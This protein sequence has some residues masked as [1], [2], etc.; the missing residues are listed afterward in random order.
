[1]IRRLSFAIASIFLAACSRNDAH[2]QQGSQPA[3]PVVTSGLVAFSATT[4]ERGQ[5]MLFK[6]R[7]AFAAHASLFTAADAGLHTDGVAVVASP[8][9]P[10]S[11]ETRVSVRLPK[12]SDGAL[13]VEAGAMRVEVKPRGFKARPV[14]WSENVAIY[15]DVAPS[16]DVYRVLGEQ[17]VED[18]YLASEERSELMFTYDIKLTDVAGLRL[19]D[20]TLEFLDAAGTPRLRATRPIAIDKAGKE[21]AGRLEV[22]GCSYDTRATGPWGRAVTPAGNSTCTVVAR[23]DGRALQYPVLVDPAWEATGKTKQTHAYHKLVVVQAGA[24]KD[25]VVLVGGTGSVASATELFD[26]NTGTWATAA[27]LPTSVTLGAGMSAAGLPNGVIVAAGGLSSG[28]S[29][30]AVASAVVRNPTSGLWFSAAAMDARA[31]HAMVPVTIGGKAVVLSIGGQ[32]SSFLG[33][34]TPALAGADYYEPP[35]IKADGSFD[36]TSGDNWFGPY[37]MNTTRAKH[38]ATVL[39]DGRVLVAGGEQYTSF[40]TYLQSAEIFDPATKAWATT[41]SMALPRSGLELQA[42]AGSGAIAAGGATSGSSTSALDSMEYFNGTT[43]TLLT[44]KLS[45]PRWFFASTR[46]SDGRLLFAGGEAYNPTTFISYVSDTADLFIPGSDPTTGIVTGAGSMN[47]LRWAQPMVNT[48]K[49]ALTTGGLTTTSTSGAETTSSDLFNTAVG[50]ACGGGCPSGLT[51]IDSVCCKLPT[52]A[53]SCDATKSEKCNNPGHEGFC[54]RPNG[55]VC[56]TNS[57]C[58]SGYCVGGFCCESACSGGCKSCDA[59]GKC[60]N[61]AAG[62]DPGLF[63]T[64]TLDVVCGKKCDG[65]GAC[66]TS[67]APEG[68]ACGVS[69]ADGGGTGSFCTI[70]ACTAWG[71]CSSKT[72]NCGLTCTTSV[73]C[74]EATKSC[75]A[76]ASGIKPGFCVIDGAC[77][78]YGDINPKDSCQVCDPPTTKTDWSTAASCIDGSVDTGSDDTGDLDTGATDDTGSTDDT[79]MED[80]TTTPMDS[81]MVEDTGPAASDDTGT[82]SADDL[83]EAKACGCRTPGES[84]NGGAGAAVALGL[85]LAVVSR[86]RR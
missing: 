17:G 75:L 62:T 38:R 82:T 63:C 83:P 28:T 33:S 15:P 68:T 35:T 80:S 58:G 61:A 12:V 54:T 43:W 71:S 31:Y 27:P 86:R 65:K 69:V 49:G 59:T 51:C 72:N 22:A 46:L 67:Y 3:A 39:G 8:T 34:S 53:T 18:L 9:G 60:V 78:A 85:A 37:K 6:A 30:T 73:T 77:Y 36:F 7:Q 2:P 64:G 42:L 56:G 79:G 48:I 4:T 20:D 1:M 50:G 10:R 11:A 40:T 29:G 81:G 41:G 16:I 44:A 84:S 45:G 5:E 13:S 66:S 25:K 74:T 47:S 26:P 23:I 76:T 70:Q 52:G 21:R 14:E 57:D 24:D 32:T 19:V 55:S